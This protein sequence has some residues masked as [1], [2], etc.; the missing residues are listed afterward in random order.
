[1][2]LLTDPSEFGKDPL[3]NDSGLASQR[4]QIWLTRCGT[5]ISD[6]YSDVM[7]GNSQPLHFN[8]ALLS[9]L[10]SLKN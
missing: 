8:I 4:E 1:M 10:K 7:G 3:R 2:A 5:I 9:L 6:I